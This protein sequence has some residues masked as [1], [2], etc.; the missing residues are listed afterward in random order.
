MLRICDV[1][2]MKTY[3]E[4]HSNNQEKEILSGKYN[5]EKAYAKQEKKCKRQDKVVK[6]TNKK[7]LEYT[8]REHSDE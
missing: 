8:E 5:A 6:K 1:G 3:R 2:P 7:V 4:L